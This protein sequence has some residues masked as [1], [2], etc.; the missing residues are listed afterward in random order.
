M[1]ALVV[2]STLLFPTFAWAGETEEV[3]EVTPEY[4]PDIYGG[5]VTPQCGWPT[6]V[7]LNG[8]TGTLVH[9]RLVVYAAHCGSNIPAVYL[10]ESLYDPVRTVGTEFCRT[11]PAYNGGSS[12]R[13][14]AFC[15]LSTPQDDVPI[16]PPLMGCE[17]GVLTP[18]REVTI[19]GFGNADANP[20]YGIKRN[21]TTTINSVQND[22]AFIGGNGLDSCQ[23]DSGG[24]VYVRLSSD[25]GGD[26]TWRVFGITSYGGACGGGGYYSMMHTQMSW[27]EQESGIDLTPC[28]SSNGE[29]QAGPECG[30][31]PNDS[32]QSNGG[33]SNGCNGGGTGVW[34]SICGPAFNA[35]PDDTP[36]TVG[37]VTPED[38]AI[39]DTG[40]A[41]TIKTDVVVEADDGDG[42]GVKSV[43][44]YIDGSLIDTDTT[45]PYDWSLTFPQ[46]VFE[47]TAV[48]TDIADNVSQPAV[49][50]IGVDA[51]PPAGS[52][53]DSGGGEDSGDGGDAGADDGSNEGGL[54]GG[55]GGLS[56]GGADG[57]D[58][59]CSCEAGP[60]GREG[61]PLAAFLLLGLAGLR[62]RRA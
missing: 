55:T 34:S 16:V 36:P 12:G 51:E 46:G 32:E 42:W 7:S 45:A 43:E 47:L 60:R 27:F 58:E 44:L 35:E 6:T 40:G 52:G 13:D 57:S 37:F 33:W 4:I 56:G 41:G 19:V 62:R 23:G 28:F 17:T 10:G 31:F 11:N 18:G 39:L 1:R 14:Q 53:G 2:A 9:P 50:K 15:V 3:D 61:A 8:C 29:W 59:G 21:V 25:I 26:D 54:D 38:G 48:A 30:F 5:T 22:E 49:I 20:S 24:P